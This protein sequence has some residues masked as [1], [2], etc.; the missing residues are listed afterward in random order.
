MNYD[1]RTREERHRFVKRANE[2][3]RLKRTNVVLTDESNRTVNQNRYLH[4][5]CRIMATET[6]V[7]EWYAKNVY[8]KQLANPDIFLTTTKDQ[9]SG[10]MISLLRSSCDLTIPEMRKALTNFRNWAMDNGYY[11]PEAE[12]EDDGK[13]TFTSEEVEEAFHQAE[14]KTSKQETQI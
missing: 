6:G 9:V 12:I 7:S 14:I 1:L 2:L 8:F 4:V 10:Q 11:L 3:L 13:V 5:L